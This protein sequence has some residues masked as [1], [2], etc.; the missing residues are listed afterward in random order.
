M[1]PARAY[2]IRDREG[3]ELRCPSLE[4][5]HVLYRQGFLTDGDLVRTE[6]ASEWVPAG[7]MPALHGAREAKRDPRRVLLLLAAA[8]AL[9][10]G[11]WLLLRR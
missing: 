1:R 6:G 10:L 3:R 8:A 4:D 11:A 5:L 7:R 9:S 2:L